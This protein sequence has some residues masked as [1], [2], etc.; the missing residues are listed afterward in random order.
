MK[1]SI[2]TTLYRSEDYLREFYRRLHAAAKSL[3]GDDFEIVFVDDGSPDKSLL[4]ALEFRTHDSHVQ[5]VELSRNFGHHAAII[6]GLSQTQGDQVFLIDCDLEEQPEWLS[7]FSEKLD[8]SGA[9]VVFGT[10]QAR[11][12][13]FWSNISG[14]MFWSALNIM[15][16]TPIPHNPMTCRLMT[17]SYVNALLEVGDRVLYLAGTFAW[18]GFKQ[19]PLPLKKIPRPRSH[20]STYNLSRKL[21]Q[22][23]DSFSSFSIAPLSLIFFI[24]LLIWLG[25]V[26]FGMGLVVWKIL[27]PEM[28]LTGFTSI[29]L[30]VWFLG[31]SIILVLGVLGMYIGKIFQEVKRR[32]LYIIKNIHK[33]EDVE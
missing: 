14:E 24:G 17:R 9:D 26:L 28:V 31:G 7:Q 11:V 27:E 23:V 25:S 21:I 22:V 19:V 8:L 33:G 29:M 5:V 18:A 2:V 15:T 12:A 32:P 30:S 13:S 6:A 1:L 4:L 3:V 16:N 10:Q 20:Q